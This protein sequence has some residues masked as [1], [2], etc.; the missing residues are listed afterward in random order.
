MRGPGNNSAI[1]NPE[2][3]HREENIDNY[4]KARNRVYV[5]TNYVL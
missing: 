2:I 5:S 1:K 3:N 4:V